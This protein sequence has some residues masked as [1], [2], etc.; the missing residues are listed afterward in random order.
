MAS[1]TLSSCGAWASHCVGFILSWT[2]G[3][4]MAVAC[5]LGCSVTRGIFPDQGSH[6]CPLIGRRIVNGW[7]TREPAC[8]FHISSSACFPFH[9]CP[10]SKAFSL[11]GYV[12]GL[13]CFSTLPSQ[14][15]VH[16][17]CAEETGNCQAPYTYSLRE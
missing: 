3:L 13:K 11:F 2:A 5:G 16:W 14:G 7:N 15:G 17:L 12:C 9:A 10:N 1:Q 4:I 6:P 8:C